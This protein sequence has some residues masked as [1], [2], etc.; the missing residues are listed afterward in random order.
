MRHNSSY[1]VP[2]HAALRMRC[3]DRA[4]AQAPAPDA[5]PL[6][7]ALGMLHCCDLSTDGEH[8]SIGELMLWHVRACDD[9]ECEKW[10][11]QKAAYVLASRLC[12]ARLAPLSLG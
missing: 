11:Q 4:C 6:D 3:L 10:K 5:M 9:Q 2:P 8:V 12:T 7:K 1:T